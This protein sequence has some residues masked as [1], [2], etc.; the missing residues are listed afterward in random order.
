MEKD[1][2]EWC[3]ERGALQH[4]NESLWRNV[5]D[6]WSSQDYNKKFPELA[7]GNRHKKTKQAKK[8]NKKQQ[9]CGRFIDA[10]GYVLLDED[11][12]SIE[13]HRGL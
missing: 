8:K 2:R 11:R 10:S 4:L 3:K 7:A 13:C 12:L 9:N 6:L 1:L 5:N